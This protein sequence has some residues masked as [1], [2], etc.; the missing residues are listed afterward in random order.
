[1]KIQAVLERRWES[2][3][4]GPSHPYLGASSGPSP[5]GRGSEAGG[6]KRPRV[7]VYGPSDSYSWD[8][9]YPF[10]A[11]WELDAPSESEASHDLGVEVVEEVG[12]T[13]KETHRI[14]KTPL[15]QF[16]MMHIFGAIDRAGL[17]PAIKRFQALIQ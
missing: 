2:G 15:F 7:T 5:K 10:G 17:Q 6:G 12:E 9:R 16:L 1:M 13:T 11:L 14:M 4:R 8:C 3:R